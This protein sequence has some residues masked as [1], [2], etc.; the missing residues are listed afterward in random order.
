MRITVLACL[1]LTLA[2]PALADDTQSANSTPAAPSA[3]SGVAAAPAGSDGTGGVAQL[4]SGTVYL[5]QEVEPNG[6]DFAEAIL[7]EDKAITTLEDCEKARSEGQTTEWGFYHPQLR[8]Y[9]GL[10]S[11]VDFRCVVSDQQLSAFRYRA[12]LEYYYLLSIDADSKLHIV[13]H[14][15]FFACRNALSSKTADHFCAEMS[16]HVGDTD[17]KE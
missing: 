16:Q 13:Q 17:D 10:P 7:L 9:R 8:K 4:P 5:L 11:R 12:P 6:S 14:K 3:A 15:N 2:L 1:L